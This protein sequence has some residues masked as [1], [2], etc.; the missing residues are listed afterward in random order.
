M[1][2]SMS[3]A[4]AVML[5]LVVTAPGRAARAE[6]ASGAVL[7]GTCFSCHGPDGRSAGAMPVIAGK[8]AAYIAAK[9]AAF[10]SGAAE[11]TVMNRIARGFSEA[12][13]KAVAK[14]LA[15]R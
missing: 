13:I 7:A 11:A 14:Y 6:M 12:E 3:M 15:A 8:S 10:K 4:A 2:L 1:R 5:A 9:L